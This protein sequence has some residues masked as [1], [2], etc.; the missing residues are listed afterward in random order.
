MC[1][2]KE[3]ILRVIKLITR[4]SPWKFLCA[5]LVV[6]GWDC[7]VFGDEAGNTKGMIVGTPEFVGDVMEK[8]GDDVI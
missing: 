3:I 2:M 8:L 5:A 4:I 1:S 7:S 6:V